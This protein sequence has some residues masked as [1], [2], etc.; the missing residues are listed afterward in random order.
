MEAAI[1]EALEWL[2]ERDGATGRT[3]EEYYE[4]KLREVEEGSSFVLRSNFQPGGGGL[5][6]PDRSQTVDSNNVYAE[7]TAE[8][9]CNRR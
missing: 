2:E 8:D 9:Q 3:T 1:A 5:V 4:E 6:G 7:R